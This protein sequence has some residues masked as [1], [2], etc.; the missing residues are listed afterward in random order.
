[1]DP[2]VLNNL[3]LSLLTNDIETAITIVTTNNVTLKD[4]FRLVKDSISKIDPNLVYTLVKIIVDQRPECITQTTILTCYGHPDTLCTVLD[5]IITCPLKK[6]SLDVWTL[7]LPHFPSW[8]IHNLDLYGQTP[9]F[10]CCDG[11]WGE[12]EEQQI[13]ER[14]KLLVEYGA[15]VNLTRRNGCTLM[16]VVLHFSL[17]RIADYLIENGANTQGMDHPF[18]TKRKRCKETSQTLCI[19]LLRKKSVGKDVIRHV[20]KLMVWSTRREDE[21]L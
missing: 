20:L 3:E 19:A 7:L 18:L 8:F 17:E 13:L 4:I 15:C 16:S 11:S 9:L 12:Y 1:M 14:I 5:D 6:I 2:Q 21:W 10:R